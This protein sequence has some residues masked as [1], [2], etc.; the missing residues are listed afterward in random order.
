M[1]KK[2]C[3]YEFWEKVLKKAKYIVAP[4]VE[5][6]EL[7]WRILARRYAAELCYTPMIHARCFLEDKT[8]RI[9]PEVFTTND[10]DRPLIVQVCS[11]LIL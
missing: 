11:L 4:M 6:S 8:Y 2:L 3:G 1:N 5:H 10:S 9:K 7:A